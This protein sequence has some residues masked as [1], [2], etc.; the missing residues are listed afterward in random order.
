MGG[1][2][3]FVHNARLQHGYQ[4]LEGEEAIFVVLGTGKLLC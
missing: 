2:F 4:Q 3:A 1:D